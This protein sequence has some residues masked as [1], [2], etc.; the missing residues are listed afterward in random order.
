MRAATRG[1]TGL[2]NYFLSST[3]GCD[4][5]GVTASQVQ[6]ER[7]SPDGSRRSQRQAGVR[8]NPLH[9]QR[10]ADSTANRVYPL[11]ESDTR[12]FSVSRY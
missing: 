12:S 5:T 3:S 10:I 9:L 7:E 2:L 11:R 6:Q 4:L 8:S 1:V